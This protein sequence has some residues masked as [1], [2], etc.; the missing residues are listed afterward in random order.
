MRTSF[1]QRKSEEEE[2]S[3]FI[4][5]TDMT[6]SFLF[7]VIILLAFFATQITPGE[8]VPKELLDARDEQISILQERLL[9]Y[10]ELEN[11]ADDVTSLRQRILDL[12]SA[13]HQLEAELSSLRD[14]LDV[15]S[16]DEMRSKIQQLRQEISRLHKLLEQSEKE[17][18][19][20]RY[21]SLAASALAGLLSRIRE[22]VRSL[23]DQIDVG[24]SRDHDALQFRGDGLFASGQ[25]IPSDSGR[26][27]MRLIARIL[28]EE[29]GCFTYE[30]G[31]EM[32]VECNPDAA[33]I[34]AIQIEGHTDSQGGD[35]LNMSL[36]AQRSTSIYD[37]MISARPA[38]LKYNNIR[39][40]PVLST[41]GYG[42]GRP[43]ADETLPGGRD[44]NRRIDIRFIMFTPIDERTVPLNISDLERVRELLEPGVGR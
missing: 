21:N 3:A 15:D 27:K 35:V 5:M 37:V 22:R 36:G 43:I 13:L 30:G 4:S 14:E 32:K 11:Q 7:I 29:I 17:N 20:E 41:A 19:I 8:T 9:L 39:G 42:E 1:R 16:T 33:A 23:N 40:Q 25:W 31:D 34:D 38:L 6:V 28:G 26:E 44:A 18:P 10:G 24:I 2:E 12:T